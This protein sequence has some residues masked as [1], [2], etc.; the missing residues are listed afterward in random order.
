[1][2]SKRKNV[3]EKEEIGDFLSID[4]YKMET[5]FEEEGNIQFSHFLEWR[6]SDHFPT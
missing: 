6:I 1:M 2:R 5:M 4:R 3:G